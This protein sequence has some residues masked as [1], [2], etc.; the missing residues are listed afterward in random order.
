MTVS[1]TT[2]EQP[3]FQSARAEA[4]PQSRDVPARPR[5][6]RGKVAIFTLL[7]VSVAGYALALLVI[8]QLSKSGA[9]LF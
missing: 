2:V 8:D 7:S 6:V 1:R 4:V 9:S 3:S 5:N